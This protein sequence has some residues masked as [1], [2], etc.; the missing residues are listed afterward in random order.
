MKCVSENC[1]PKHL[2]ARSCSLADPTMF[3]LGLPHFRVFSQQ[4][5]LPKMSAE[6]QSSAE[7]GCREWCKDLIYAKT[8][9]L[10]SEVSGG[11]FWLPSPPSS[12][13]GWPTCARCNCA[14]LCGHHL[15]VFQKL[16]SGIRE[17]SKIRANPRILHWS[18]FVR[19]CSSS[20]SC[21]LATHVV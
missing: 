5:I 6:S 14:A 20:R 17:H 7:T 18:H 19:P 15:S 1:S 10:C 2:N 16:E 21:C 12:P 13:F 9:P 4:N 11:K 8:G 3:F